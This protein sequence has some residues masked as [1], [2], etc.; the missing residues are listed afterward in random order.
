MHADGSMTPRIVTLDRRDR[1]PEVMDQPGLDAQLHG[2]ALDSLQRI[3]RLSR[4]AAGLWGPI[5]ALARESVHA[6]QREDA[7]PQPLR[8]LDVASG[9]GDVAIGLARAAERAGIAVEVEGCDVSPTAVRYA[10]DSAARLGMTNVTFRECDVLR[11]PLPAGFDVVTCSLFLHHLAED[12]AERLLRNMS[13]S[14]RRLVVISDLRRTRL[15]Y[16]LAQLVC[17]VLTRSPVVRVDGPLS[18]AAA[19]TSREALQLA[20]RSGMAGAQIARRWPQRFLLT[21]RRP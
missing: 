1:Q 11:D 17:R 18:V 5:Q 3:N 21:W 9:G 4:T 8:I 2:Q 10:R 14:A 16:L 19:F 13:T 12:E 7:P 6:E 15:G 20:E